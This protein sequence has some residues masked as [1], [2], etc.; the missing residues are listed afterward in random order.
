MYRLNIFLVP[1]Y[2]MG[3]I[4]KLNISQFQAINFKVNIFIF[5]SYVRRDE[6]L[7]ILSMYTLNAGC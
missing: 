7:H 1:S 4:A 3:F 6:E 2:A 5:S